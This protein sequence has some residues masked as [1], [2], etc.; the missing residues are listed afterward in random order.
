[1]KRGKQSSGMPRDVARSTQATNPMQKGAGNYGQ[2]SMI[3]V[4]QMASPG[5]VGRKR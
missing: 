2:R 3:K 4:P 5:H 1:M